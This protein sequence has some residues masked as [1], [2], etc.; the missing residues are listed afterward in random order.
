LADY[1]FSGL[2]PSDFETLCRDLLEKALAIPLQSFTTGRDRGIDLRHAPTWQRDWIVQCKHYA[3]SGYAS[4]LSHLKNKELAKIEKLRPSRYIVATSVGLSPTNVDELFELLSPYCLSKH[5]IYGRDDLNAVL[6]RHPEIEQSHFKLWLTS[7]PVLSRVLHNDV[8]VQSWLT[9]EQIRQR[10]SLYVQTGSFEKARAKLAEDHVC[11]LSGV[12]GIGKTT[13]AEMILVEHLLADWQVISIHQNVTE[14]QRLFRHD[15]DAKQVFY[16]D[17]FLGQISTGDKLGKNE[18]RAL[19]QLIASVARTGNKR[20]LLT[21]REYILAQAKAE[22]EQLARSSIDFYQF[23]VKCEDYSD[24]DKARILANHLYF[25]RVPQ[26][27]IA[28]LVKG[29]AYRKVISH[30]N[31]NPRVIEWMTNAKATTACAPAVYP[32]VF[33]EQLNNPSELWRHAF[34]KQISEAGRHLLLVLASCGDGVFL[35]DLKESFDTFYLYRANRFGFP[36]FPASFES[37]LEQ[38]EG[39]FIRI[40]RAETNLVVSFH[41]PSIIDFLGQRLSRSHGDIGDL[42]QS[43]VFFEQIARLFEVFRSP[44]SPESGI[45][46]TNPFKPWLVEQAIDR[47]LLVRGIRLTK[48]EG[49]FGGWH[50]VWTSIWGRLKTSCRIA[51]QLGD[52]GLQAAVVGQVETHF[53]AIDTHA[54]DLAEVTALLDLLGE[55]SWCDRAVVERWN[56][57]LLQSLLAMDDDFEEGLDGLAAA[58]NWFVENRE[59]FDPAH[60]DAFVERI[61]NNVTREVE[62]NSLQQGDPER[63][64]GDLDTV[65]VIAKALNLDFSQEEEQ[66]SEAISERTREDGRDDD[67]SWRGYRDNQASI[68]AIFDSLVE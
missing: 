49:G 2:A 20:F 33:L 47:T 65:Q 48:T 12:P 37:A 23:V 29:H 55:C 60:I 3:R 42:L 57:R 51:S 34:E 1:D 52:P 68:E 21:T 44:S 14:G 15:S 45:S 63:L 40:D 39:N 10:L 17:D 56:E 6:R 67:D 35:G 31:Y 38:L 50:R 46:A 22:H 7:E 26:E 53:Q 58:A 30:R 16:Y 28:A 54:T 59:Q 18:D 5:D 66:L 24:L 61:S 27:H 43:A 11:I 36:A 41:N 4:L 62:N 64:G 32:E 13:L 25:A 9:E 8:F 19:L